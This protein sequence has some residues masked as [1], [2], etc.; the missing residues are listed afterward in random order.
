MFFEKLQV[1]SIASDSFNDIR[2]VLI[3]QILEDDLDHV[4]ALEEV[5]LNDFFLS[6]DIPK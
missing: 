3:R 1:C 4:D 6:N 5:S 2:D